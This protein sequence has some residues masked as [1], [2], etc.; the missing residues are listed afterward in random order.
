MA[1]GHG[2]IP[3]PVLPELSPCGMAATHIEV[4]NRGQGSAAYSV[5]ASVPWLHVTPARGQVSL[6]GRLEVTADWGAVPSGRSG[7]VV[8]VTSPGGPP[9]RVA[10]PVWKPQAG[11]SG[12]VESNGCVSIEAPHFDRAVESHG[13][14]WK[15]LRDYGHALGAV[16]AFPVTAA[17]MMP[18]GDSPRLEF[19]V[20]LFS[21]GDAKVDAVAAPTLNFTPGHGLR[22][23]LSWDDEAPQVQEYYARVGED[24]GA[25]SESVLEGVRHVILE[26]RL[27]RPGGTS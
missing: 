9:V 18:G 15:V 21:D 14:E 13:I 1:H 12:F 4:F 2:S 6:D 24:R 26:Q 22:F 20:Y 23:A 27:S 16:T 17:S 8:T 25:W 7:A 10:V 19:D 11:L 5:E 3:A